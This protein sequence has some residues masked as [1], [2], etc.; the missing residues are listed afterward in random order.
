VRKFVCFILIIGSFVGFSNKL[1]KS[2]LQRVEMVR[3]SIDEN[4]HMMELDAL[5]KENLVIGMG[6]CVVKSNSKLYSYHYGLRN[7]E[8]NIP[9]DDQT[10][11]RIASVSK[12]VTAIGIMQLVEK[13]DIRLDG[14]I[15][16]YLKKGV[17]NKFYSK[18]PITVRMLLSHTSS[19]HDGTDYSN[20]ITKTYGEENV[21]A[22]YELFSNESDIWINR[23][24][25]T[26]FNYCNL[27]YGIIATIIENVADQRFDKY[28]HKHILEP[29]E[30]DGGFNVSRIHTK[31]KISVLY[32]GDIPQAD[33]YQNAYQKEKDF[34]LGVNGIYFSPHGGLRITVDDLAKIMQ[35]LINKGNYKGTQIL[36]KTTVDKMEAMHW[37]NNGI[38]GNTYHNHYLA[39]GLGLQKTTETPGGD[40]IMPGVS[41]IGHHGDAYGLLADIYYNRNKNIGFVFICNGTRNEHGYKPGKKSRFFELEEEVFDFVYKNFLKQ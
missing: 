28:I 36:K 38:N 26:Y 39:W 24:P 27:N 34:T 4:K 30:I 6:L 10:L 32:R 41:F 35:M 23:K 22:I 29:L 9:A 31:D 19:L 33:N 8:L 14:D 3:D 1:F 15:N 17:R 40:Y 2:N 18:T 37:K 20:F 13:G 11:Y 7:L 5:A 16:T 12:V 21:P 25:G